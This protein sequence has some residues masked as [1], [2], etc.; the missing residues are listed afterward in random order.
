LL[1]LPFRGVGQKYPHLRFGDGWISFYNNEA[2]DSLLAKFE[3]AIE[4]KKAYFWSMF[5]DWTL[6]LQYVATDVYQEILF[7]LM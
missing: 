7:M 5:G 4:C 1:I 6:H 2:N 3:S